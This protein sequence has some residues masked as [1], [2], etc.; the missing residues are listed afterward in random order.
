MLFRSLFPHR[1][2]AVVHRV[3]VSSPFPVG[4]FYRYWNFQLDRRVVIFPR[5][6]PCSIATPD[7]GRG[8]SGDSNL[9]A[10]G[11]DGELERI[12][13]YSGSEPMKLIHWKLSA[14]GE[15]LLVKEFGSLA[16]EPLLINLQEIAAPDLEGRIS[17][18]AWLVKRWVESRPVGLRLGTAVIPPASGRRQRLRLLTE[19]AMF[20]ADGE[21]QQ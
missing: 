20:G 3:R 19:L 13:G 17:G 21:R 7:A 9:R 15:A 2:E 4:F 18:A 11:S 8:K 1:G 16:A 12:A 10:R 14:R 5:M 6:L